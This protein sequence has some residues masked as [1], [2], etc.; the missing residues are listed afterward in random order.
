MLQK[1]DIFLVWIGNLVF[2]LPVIVND[3]YRAMN[4]TANPILYKFWNENE[5]LKC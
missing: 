5:N 1:F 2:T 4:D 3:K